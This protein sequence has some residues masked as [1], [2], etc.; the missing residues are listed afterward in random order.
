MNMT[1]ASRVMPALLTRMSTGPSALADAVEERRDRRLVGDVALPRPGA[2][3]ARRARAATNSRAGASRS[4]YAIADRRAALGEQLGDAAADAARAAGD[5][6]DAAVELK[7]VEGHAR[8]GAAMIHRRHSIYS[9]GATSRRLRRT[10]L[11][12]RRRSRSC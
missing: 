7:I 6:G 9:Y 5:D 1:C 2:A 3:A 4:R 8:V 10:A 12:A 11:T